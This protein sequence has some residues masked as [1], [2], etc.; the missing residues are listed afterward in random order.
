MVVGMPLSSL[1]SHAKQGIKENSK[2]TAETN[3]PAQSEQAKPSKGVAVG[4]P[5][6]EPP[7]CAKA[8]TSKAPPDEGI[9]KVD[10]VSEP[11]SGWFIASVIIAGLLFLAAGVTLI[12]I[13]R[14]TQAIELQ[15]TAMMEADCAMFL[16]G[17]DKLIH[18][19]PAAPNGALSH[20]FQWNCKNVGKSP[21]FVQQIASRFIVIKSLDEL[22]LEP[23]YPATKELT[24]EYEPVL[25]GDML[26][27]RIYSPL[28]TSMSFEEMEAEH[29]GGRCLLYAFGFV[30]Y[31]DIYQR[32]QE[33][34]FGVVYKPAPTF[35]PAV[36]RWEIAGP[37]SYNR[38]KNRNKKKKWQ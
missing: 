21:A 1:P 38:Y 6:S 13:W 9:Y 32:S 19:N 11:T 36:D 12:I 3:S 33:T 31:L 17:W 26:P 29:R 16:I 35:N 22:P 28:E 10:V 15:A 7:S 4:R 5:V 34:R 24:N 14:Q 2:A 37:S 18:I 27:R 20:C 8:N 25:A 23:E 30:K